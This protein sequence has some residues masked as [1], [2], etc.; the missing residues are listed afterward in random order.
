MSSGSDVNRQFSSVERR[1]DERLAVIGLS[2][3]VPGANDAAKYWN[4]LVEGVESVDALDR[5]AMVAAGITPELIDDPNYVPVKGVLQ[6]FDCFDA[7]LFGISAREATLT[8]PQQR[9]FLEQALAA[10]EDAGYGSA[11][12][13]P[14]R[15]GVFAGSGFNTYFPWLE[16]ASLELGLDRNAVATM[17]GNAPDYL[18]T[19]VAH[20]LNCQGP[21][22]SVQT[23]CS[24]ALTAVHLAGQSL[25]AEECDLAIAGGVTVRIPQMAGHLSQ[26]GGILSADGHCRPFDAEATGTINGCG[27]GAVVLRRLEDALKDGDPVRCVVLASAINNDGA[28][29]QAFTAPN[30]DAQTAVI[31]QA[32][33]QAGLTAD[34]IDYLEAH[35]TGTQLGDAVEIAAAARALAGRQRRCRIGSV[36][37]NIGHLDAAAG[38][39]SLIKMIFALERG[40]IPPSIN[41]RLPNPACKFE[42]MAFE[43]NRALWSWPTSDRP[44]RAGVSSFGFG[45]TNV[46]VV[47]EQ[48]PPADV[49]FDADLPQLI[50][51]QAATVGALDQVIVRLQSYLGDRPELRLEDVAHTLQVGRQPLQRRLAFVARSRH[52][53]HAKLAVLRSADAREAMRSPAVVLLLDGRTGAVTGTVRKFYREDAAFRR[54]LDDLA[55]EID[56]VCGA[57]VRSIL[58]AENPHGA[59][60]LA[61]FALLVAAARAARERINS[62]GGLVGIGV[63]EVAALVVAG[64]VKIED[65]IRHLGTFRHS[66]AAGRSRDGTGA[67]CSSAV[68]L[69]EPS[70]P[71]ASVSLGRR[72]NRGDLL[73][74]YCGQRESEDPDPDAALATLGLPA[75]PVLLWM[76]SDMAGARLPSSIM[77]ENVICQLAD[78]SDTDECLLGCLGKLWALGAAVDWRKLHDPRRPRRVSLPSYPY[79]RQRHFPELNLIPA[80][81]VTLAEEA[82][83]SML[84]LPIWRRLGRRGRHLPSSCVIVVH[85]HDVFSK[86]LVHNLSLRATVREIRAAQI[87]D[88]AHIPQDAHLVYVCRALSGED[89]A[90]ASTAEITHLLSVARQLPRNT[91][92]LDVVTI[93]AFEAAPGAGVVGPHGAAAAG[94][95]KVMRQEAFAPALGRTI[96]A[97]P[98]ALNN[99]AADAAAARVAEELL[100]DRDHELIC[101]RGHQRLARSFERA[102]KEV[103][104]ER[105]GGVYFVSGGTGGIGQLIARH[106]ARRPDTRL[107]LVG[108][109]VQPHSLGRLAAEIGIEEERLFLCAADVRDVTSL[110]SAVAATVRQFGPIT[111]VIH[112][113]GVAAAGPVAEIGAE[114][115]AQVMDTKLGGAINLHAA[116]AEHNRG[117][118]PDVT[119]LMSS[120]V[121]LL[122]GPGLAVYAGANAAVEAYA[123]AVGQATGAR[124]TALALDR[125]TG[126][127]MA[128]KP[129]RGFLHFNLN[130]WP[131]LAAEHRVMD[132]AIVPGTVVLGLMFEAVAERTGTRAIVADEVTLLR[133]VELVENGPDGIAIA[134][135]PTNAGIWTAD[136]ISERRGKSSDLVARGS[137]RVLDRHQDNAARSGFVAAIMPG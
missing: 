130:R 126:V 37:G 110:S 11:E 80:T 124:V 111:G 68:S 72:L 122:G 32:I 112:L 96:D 120:L 94:F 28:D 41:C 91:A 20:K 118:V 107:A 4:N 102:S 114:Q 84:W 95:V 58:L 42:N 54:S 5:D 59:D 15:C 26:S 75:K 100:V 45:G 47:L 18:A 3:R 108:R 39:A 65:A 131:W 104:P 117:H 70:M 76:R 8:D 19:R 34:D 49:G 133:P 62:L 121:G 78:D 31:A 55:A 64:A 77:P 92:R 40:L 24:T 93:G 21:A 98:V 38:V 123:A 50:C 127:G 6:D 83:A 74:R 67:A 43:V 79:E 2:C 33:A 35:A 23:A 29:K 52:E 87:A 119:L 132:K 109:S 90:S 97:D 89:C 48:A 22:L 17:L 103:V 86:A 128:E 13:R 113:A 57:D 71:V 36:K 27:V 46:H 129:T 137:F 53:L 88:G 51:L 7:A 125:V 82:D 85:H 99:G 14:L 135:K 105:A 1:E 81:P 44:R 63:G 25:L 134:P 9:V 136:V 73:D 101:C 106:L 56:T 116:L 61:T 10:L 66:A 16:R 60:E 115:I 30:P 69:G 12:Y